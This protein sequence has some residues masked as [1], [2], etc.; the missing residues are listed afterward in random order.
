MKVPGRVLFRKEQL[1]CGRVIST[2]V[3]KLF[4]TLETMFGARVLI[5][6]SGQFS[7]SVA[8]CFMALHHRIN[9]A[10]SLGIKLRDVLSRHIHLALERLGFR[11]SFSVLCSRPF[12]F[13]SETLSLNSQ[14]LESALK[15]PGDFTEPFGDSCVG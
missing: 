4:Q 2:A 12:A 9:G 11:I 6:N 7:L 13:S 8:N 1:N 10:L 5:A 14:P 3:V 15:L